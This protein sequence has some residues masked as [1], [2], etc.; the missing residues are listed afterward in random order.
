MSIFYKI[1]SVFIANVDVVSWRERA[2]MN[3]A[4]SLKYSPRHAIS[5]T[6]TWIVFILHLFGLFFPNVKYSLACLGF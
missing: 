1:I 3:P 4:Y 6:S 5:F 2:N